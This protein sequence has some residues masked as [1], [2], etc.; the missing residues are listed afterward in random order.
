MNCHVIPVGNLIGWKSHKYNQVSK[1]S[2]VYVSF[3]HLK[4]VG[5][6]T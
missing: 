6:G 3:M 1:K 4:W 5:L 2:Y